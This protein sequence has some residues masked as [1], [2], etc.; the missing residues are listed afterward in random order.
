[1]GPT[2]I[3]LYAALLPGL[4]LVT[5]TGPLRD[6]AIYLHAFGLAWLLFFQTSSSSPQQGSD[7]YNLRHVMFNLEIPPKTL[8]FNMGLWD[9]NESGGINSDNGKSSD[10]DRC[11]MKY[12]DACEKLVEAVL[13][14]MEMKHASNVLDV[15]YGC[16]DSCFMLAD[17]YEC[18]VTGL[19]NEISQWRVSQQRL[20][21]SPSPVARQRNDRIN[22]LCASATDDKLSSVIDKFGPFDHI[23]SID[24]AYHYVTR[25]KFLQ[26]ALYH[27]L[28]GGTLGLYDLTVHPSLLVKQRTRWIA[29]IVGRYVLGIP[30]ENMVTAE[31]YRDR[32]EAM[33]YAQVEVEPVPADR[34]FGGLS[35]FI[36]RQYAQAEAWDILPPFANRMFMLASAS[37]FGLLARKQWVVPVI[38]SGRRRAYAS[39]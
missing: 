8:W 14:R 2:T 33:G 26:A 9:A 1:M 38:V 25:W 35:R 12:S 15:G 5:T 31:A 7:M 22:F 37:L 6:I 18:K 3:A 11:H 16:G 39:C 20:Q 13:E 23:I 29:E 30:K 24:S 19:T 4:C 27:L 32:L 10:D 17:R 28:P 36:R 21:A 34:V